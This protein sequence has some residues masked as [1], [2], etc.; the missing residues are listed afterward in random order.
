MKKSLVKTKLI[1]PLTLFEKK[2][3]FLFYKKVV[4]IFK[5]KFGFTLSC[6]TF[7]G[8]NMTWIILLT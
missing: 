2:N 1:N 7:V 5:E 8:F 4:L 6:L 3:F